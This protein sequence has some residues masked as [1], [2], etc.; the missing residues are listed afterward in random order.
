MNA[1]QLKIKKLLAN[2]NTALLLGVLVIAIV[3]TLGYTSRVKKVT[4]PTNIPVAVKDIQPRTKIDSSM[5]EYVKVPKGLL[6]DNV[7]L[8]SNEIIGSYVAINAMVPK[9]SLFYKGSVSGKQQSADSYIDAIP[10]DEKKKYTLFYLPVSME[11]SYSNS[12]LPGRYIDI[13]VETTDDSLPAVGRFV[14]NIK[15]LAVK[16]ADGNNVFEN[17]EEKRAPAQVIFAVPEDIHLL[18]RKAAAFNEVNGIPNVKLAPVPT[19]FDDKKK[20]WVEPKIVNEEIKNI[21]EEYSVY[22][23]ETFEK[24][25]SIEKDKKDK[26]DKK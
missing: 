2:K 15:V 11:T 9:G 23:P 16:D 13:Y 26:K 3:L 4:T 17:S 19:G 7:I 5:I 25:Q 20:K 10:K 21:I 18:L 22:L 1:T 6:T 12:I 14:S 24:E 8:N